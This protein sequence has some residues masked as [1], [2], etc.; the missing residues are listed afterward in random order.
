MLICGEYNQPRLSW[1]MGVE[2]LRY[3]ISNPMSPAAAALVDGVDF[4]NMT[5]AYL[6]RNYLGRVLELVFFP[7]KNVITILKAVAR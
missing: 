7:F 6:R 4:L 2:G 1:T 3:N 5:Q